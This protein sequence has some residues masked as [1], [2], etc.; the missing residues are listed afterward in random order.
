MLDCVEKHCEII[1]S[2]EFVVNEG[3]NSS[4]AESF[5]EMAGEVVACVKASETEKHIDLCRGRRRRIHGRE[6]SMQFVKSLHYCTDY[7]THTKLWFSITALDKNKSQTDL[8][9]IGGTTTF[10]I[11]FSFKQNSIL[12]SEVNKKERSE[13]QNNM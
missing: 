4:Q 12:K 2:A 1:S 9:K 7:K 5:L 11:N 6:A 13:I 8:V 3:V 10:G